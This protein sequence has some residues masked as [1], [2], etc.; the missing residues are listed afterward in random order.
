MSFHKRYFDKDKIFEFGKS[1][2]YQDFNKWI[3]N[4]DARISTDTFSEYFLDAYFLLEK[5]DRLYLYVSLE[6]G[7]EFVMDLVKCIRVC[8]NKK[9]SKD[10]KFAL[11]RYVNLFLR[12]WSEEC[13]NYKNLLK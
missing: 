10:H 1:Y 13:F 7:E 3:S 12:K 6:N 4:P 8:K 9:N 11:D 5:R 2:Q